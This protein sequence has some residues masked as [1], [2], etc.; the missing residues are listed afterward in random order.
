MTYV[1]AAN[2]TLVLPG[3]QQA[4]VTVLLP[5]RMRKSRYWEMITFDRRRD[6]KEMTCWE[7]SRDSCQRLVALP[8]RI[9][10]AIS[11]LSAA[12]ARLSAAISAS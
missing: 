8:E 9:A 5:F 10:P 11:R 7:G 6:L 4:I 3:K 2:T 12:S 1:L